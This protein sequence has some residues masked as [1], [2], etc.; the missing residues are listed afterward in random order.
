MGGRGV[1]EEEAVANI[2]EVKAEI[3]DMAGGGGGRRGGKGFWS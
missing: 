3:E 2:E 1:K